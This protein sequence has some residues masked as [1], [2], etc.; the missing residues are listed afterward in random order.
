MSYVAWPEIRVC[1][2]W[3]LYFQPYIFHVQGY[4][5]PGACSRKNRAER[6]RLLQCGMMDDDLTEKTEL[7]KQETNVTTKDQTRSG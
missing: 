1:G 4:R 6:R 3:G 2:V 5:G 7:N